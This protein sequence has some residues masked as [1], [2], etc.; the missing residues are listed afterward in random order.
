MGRGERAASHYTQAR[1][2]QRVAIIPPHAG[3]HHTEGRHLPRPRPCSH[4]CTCAC[5]RSC[6][7]S[8]AQLPPAHARSRV[9]ANMV[10]SSSPLPAHLHKDLKL[11]VHHQPV[12]HDGRGAGRGHAAWPQLAPWLEQVR[13]CGA[14]EPNGAKTQGGEH[15]PPHKKHTQQQL[16]TPASNASENT[17]REAEASSR[18]PGWGRSS[19]RPLPS[20]GAPAWCWVRL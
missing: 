19:T 15:L 3:A 10:P 5:P 13:E 20:S 9:N 18:G 17:E 6:P 4:A 8:L 16:A 14:L 12:R 11:V 1:T 2:T 7:C